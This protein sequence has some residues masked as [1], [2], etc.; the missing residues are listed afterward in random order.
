MNLK[1]PTRRTLALSFLAATCLVPLAGCRRRNPMPTPGEENTLPLP[2]TS[3]P[4]PA[5]NAHD[6]EKPDAHGEEKPGTQANAALPVSLKSGKA[7]Y[8]RGENVEFSITVRN[9]SQTTQNLQ[10]TS[11]QSFDITARAAGAKEDAW[12]W[13]ADK[14]FSMALRRQSLRAGEEQVFKATWD[15]SAGDGQPLPR[16]KYTIAAEITTN[17]RLNAEPITIELN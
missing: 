10:F 12:R 4:Q 3:K 8:G 17:P 9:A 7:T 5:P 14:I 11:G 13:S 2:S 1:F 15:Q 16:G 6:G